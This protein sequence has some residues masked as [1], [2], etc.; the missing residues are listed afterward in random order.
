M[1]PAISFRNGLWPFALCRILS[2]RLADAVVDCENFEGNAY[3]VPPIKVPRLP[4]KILLRDTSTSWRHPTNTLEG[5]IIFTQI[6]VF[7][8]DLVNQ[9]RWFSFGWE[10]FSL[11]LSDLSGCI[12]HF[13]APASGSHSKSGDHPL[14][15][16]VRI[17]LALRICPSPLV[18]QPT[19]LTSGFCSNSDTLVQLVSFTF[20]LSSWSDF[21]S[22]RGVFRS[23]PR[24]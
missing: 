3:E 19:L 21:G 11:I 22:V 9:A 7:N 12:L 18:P 5:V 14:F 1:L 13:Q 10:L 4:G 16:D 15:K 23:R 6:R 20:G 24:C 17:M 8:F 2:S